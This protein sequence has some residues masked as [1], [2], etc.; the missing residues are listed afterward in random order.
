M[1]GAAGPPWPSPLPSSPF[2]SSCLVSSCHVTSVLISSFAPSCDI[3]DVLHMDPAAV[4]Y[5]TV[6]YS[7][8]QKRT[9]CLAATHAAARR[10]VAQ[11]QRTDSR[12]ASDGPACEGSVKSR[13]SKQEPRNSRFMQADHGIPRCLTRAKPT[14]LQEWVVTTHQTRTEATSSPTVSATLEL[15]ACR[16]GDQEAPFILRAI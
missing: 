7:T 13:G 14:N 10:R 5:S 11:L 12:P 8:A 9:P 15:R 6:Q 16:R 3:H 4:L 2:V 1:A